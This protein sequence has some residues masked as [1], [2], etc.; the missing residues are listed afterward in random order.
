MGYCALEA[1]REKPVVLQFV[2][3]PLTQPRVGA[4]KKM[5]MRDNC[6]VAIN[7]VFHN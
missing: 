5:N 2:F 1:L 7:A 3:Q 4:R 6:A